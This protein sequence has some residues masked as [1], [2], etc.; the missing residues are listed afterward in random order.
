MVREAAWTAWWPWIA[1]LAAVAVA[2]VAAAHVVLN[3]RDV[4]AAIGWT[5]LIVLSPFFGALAYYVLGIN[6]IRRRAA[7]LVAERPSRA[8]AAWV[9]DPKTTIEPPGEAHLRQLSEMI[10]RSTGRPLVAGN[11]VTPL[12]D[13]DEAYPAML[14]AIASAEHGIVLL[15]YIFDYDAVGRRFV[16]ALADAVARGVAVRVLID[17]VGARYSRPPTA[18]ALVRRGV[19]TADFLPPRLPLPLRSAYMNLRN[20]RK[21]MI[22]DR[23]TAFVGGMNIRGG[24]LFADTCDVARDGIHDLHF[25][26]EGP[27]V[28]ELFAVAAQ[29][30]HFTTRESLTGAAWSRE[31]ESEP[32]AYGPTLARVIPDGPDE[33][34]ENLRW[35][36]MSAIA[37]ARRSIR[38]VTPYFL[39]EAPLLAVLRLAALRGVDVEIL[40]P[41]HNNLRVVQ[42]ASTAQMWQV[43][44]PGCRVW[45]T[46]P[47]FDHSKLFVV[48]EAWCLVGSTNWDARSLRLNFE[49]CVECHDL[50]LARRLG[51]AIDAKRARSREL[52]LAEVDGRSLPVR[53]RDG[54]ARL[55]APYL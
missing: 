29:D 35:T 26:M 43:L 40:V 15:T 21:L 46:P 47:P 38:I 14:A 24:C 50:D 11:A 3:K 19:R 37:S 31:E 4:R 20:H 44:E 33:D 54:V 18:R 51:Q 42:W 7:R 53:L 12:V 52:T 5:G 36:L 1:G 30:W 25:R 48:D 55:F 2:A 22:V 45:L 8:L 13:G 23:E 6:R 27:V 39:P 17:G 28:D 10:W 34:F 9:S 49:L 16:D 32:S 41:A